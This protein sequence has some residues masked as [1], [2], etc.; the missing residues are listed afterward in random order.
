MV[1]RY[2]ELS[3]DFVVDYLRSRGG[4]RPAALDP[5][6]GI[7]LR[8]AKKVRRRALSDRT[9]DRPEN[10]AQMADEFFPFP[11]VPPRF[12]PQVED[13]SFAAGITAR[14]AAQR[15]LGA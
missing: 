2:F 7:N 8:L 3:F 9:V 1:D 15:A 6:G 10:L 4:S 5:V 13:A 11:D 14:R 12:W